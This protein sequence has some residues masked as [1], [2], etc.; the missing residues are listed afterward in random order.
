MFILP[1]SQDCVAVGFVSYNTRK[2]SVHVTIQ[3]MAIFRK[4]PLFSICRTDLGRRS[5][6]QEEFDVWP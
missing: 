5:K 2:V 3:Q 4:T 1:N 6:L